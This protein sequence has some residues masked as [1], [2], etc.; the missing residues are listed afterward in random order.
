METT[1]ESDVGIGFAA[2][3]GFLALAAAGYTLVAPT[4]R[5]TA[6]GFAATVTLS[7]LLVAAIHVYWD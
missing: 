2:I 1:Q 6:W 5:L 4:Q 3:F 7:V